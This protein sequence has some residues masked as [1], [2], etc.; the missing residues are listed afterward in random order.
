M[1]LFV[2]LVDS[3]CSNTWNKIRLLV[4]ESD[5]FGIMVVGRFPITIAGKEV[6]HLLLLLWRKMLL[7]S[8]HTIIG[9]TVAHDIHYPELDG[10]HI[11]MLHLVVEVS[12]APCRLKLAHTHKVGARSVE[13]CIG[14]NSI[15]GSNIGGLELCRNKSDALS[16]AR[17]FGIETVHPV[18]VHQTVDE[19]WI[20]KI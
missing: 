9:G 16:G 20:I 11:T 18:V 1:K 14:I 7:A 13:V 2:P 12:E 8:V 15:A 10:L 6:L 17:T 5:F 19:L 3:L 4:S